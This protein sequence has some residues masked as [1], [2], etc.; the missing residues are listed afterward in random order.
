MSV[1]KMKWS[2]LMTK[3]FPSRLSASISNLTTAVTSANNLQAELIGSSNILNVYNEMLIILCQNQNV[4]SPWKDLYI[5]GSSFKLEDC[6]YAQLL[7]QKALEYTGF[8]KKI[9]TD[10]GIQRHLVYGKSYS[11]S[12][13]ASSTE[14]G[15]DSVTPQNSNLY[16]PV[17]A[18]ADTMFDEAIGNYASSI[19]KNKASSSSSSSGSS[20]TNVSGTTWEEEKR[21]MEMLFYSELIN[22]IATI[23]ER[24]YSYYALDTMP[25]PELMKNFVGYLDEV[26]D[27]FKDE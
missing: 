4:V 10:E 15:T 8:Y 1:V 16:N 19:N 23:P 25:A 6:R 2:E 22:Y 21:N 7:L 9:L 17:E 27:I 26:R 13:T 5:Y 3:V 14:R 24:I 11:N 20:T 18:T 12:G